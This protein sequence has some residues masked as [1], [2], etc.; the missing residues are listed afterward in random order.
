MNQA[1]QE[2]FASVLDCIPAMGAQA[3]CPERHPG[4][5]RQWLMNTMGALLVPKVKCWPLALVLYFADRSEVP[6]A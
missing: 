2:A 6:Q 5:Y 1:D 3:P 4:M